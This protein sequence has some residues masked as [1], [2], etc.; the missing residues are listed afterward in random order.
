MVVDASI[1]LG[2]S[3]VGK[4]SC[5]LKMLTCIIVCLYVDQT[6]YTHAL[7]VI[8]TARPLASLT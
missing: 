6:Y 4:T 3:V 7:T 1:T 8:I 2:D 5:R